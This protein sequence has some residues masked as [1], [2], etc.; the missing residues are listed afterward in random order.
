[1]SI[2][3]SSTFFLFFVFVFAFTFFSFSCRLCILPPQRKRPCWKNI[4]A[5]SCLQQYSARTV[6]FFLSGWYGPAIFH[7]ICSLPQDVVYWW[8]VCVDEQLSKRMQSAK[9]CTCVSKLCSSYEEKKKHKMSVL[10]L[11]KIY[12]IPV[13]MKS[14]WNG[15]YGSLFFTWDISKWNDFLNKKKC[16]LGFV[17]WKWLICW[18]IVV[19]YY[20][21][22]MC[23]RSPRT[24]KYYASIL[25]QL[26]VV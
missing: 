3:S 7:L 15:S 1:M 18:I 2:I 23:V 24:T 5:T 20:F 17:H 16:R 8:T 9:A 25:V 21:Y 19:C 13:H 4:P 6:V 26:N 11:I 14:A 10:S 22:L 12:S